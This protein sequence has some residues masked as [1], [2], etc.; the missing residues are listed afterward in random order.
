MKMIEHHIQLII[1][2]NFLIDGKNLFDQ[3][4]KNELKTYEHIRTIAAG[5]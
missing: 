4:I 3:P 1:S 2:Q 5:Q